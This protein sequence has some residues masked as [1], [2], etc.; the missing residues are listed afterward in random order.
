[1]QIFVENVTTASMFREISSVRRKVF[2]NE[3]LKK[4]PPLTLETTGTAWHLVARTAEL[5]LPVAALSVVETTAD[6]SLHRRYALH[7]P[8]NARVA[9]LTQLAVLTSFRGLG[10]PR[11]LISEAI[12]RVVQP[13][14]F[15]FTWLLFDA[16]RAESC[17]LVADFDYSA[18]PYVLQTEYGLCRVLTRDERRSHGREIGA[19]LWMT[20]PKIQ[21][22][23]LPL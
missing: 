1:M 20:E 17:T 16:S 5:G 8:D 10:I 21:E 7:F 4:I 18:S 15:D 11:Q 14:N 19:N 3:W 2:E 6:H 13:Q 9:R 22:P 23:T 12:Q